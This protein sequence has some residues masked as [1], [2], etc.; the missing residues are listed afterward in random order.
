MARTEKILPKDWY[1]HLLEID[2]ENDI[3]QNPVI[4]KKCHI[5]YQKFVRFASIQRV[6]YENDIVAEWHDFKDKYINCRL[7]NV[8]SSMW[9]KISKRVFERDH[10]TCAY[11]GKVG[12]KL[13]VD[14]MMP[15][16]R[17]G[18]SEMSN[19]ITACQHCN[20]QKHDKTVSEYLEWRNEHE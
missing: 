15:V 2:V 20:R 6:S 17:G 19:L 4:A 11:C 3:R 13:D 7:S 1:E 9:K 8:D 12:G 5:Y 10:Y 16:S 14:H 18:T